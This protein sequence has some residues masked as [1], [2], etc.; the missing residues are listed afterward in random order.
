MSYTKRQFVEAALEEISIAS[1]HFDASPDMLQSAVRRLDAMLAT[2]NAQGIRINYLLPTEPE[3]SNL[4]DETE[5]PD[6]ANE[7]IITNLAIKLAPSYGRVVP[8]DT[9]AT[10][11]RSY[12][13]LLV[14]HSKPQEM[15][16]GVLP[17]GAGHKAAGYS[18]DNYFPDVVEP[19]TTGQDDKPILPGQL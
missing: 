16:L 10:A 13:A 4:D 2:W 15:Q 9:K 11:K 19:I 7:A 5:V 12:N 1:Y 3:N 18:G 14:Q 17:K 8:T 6:S